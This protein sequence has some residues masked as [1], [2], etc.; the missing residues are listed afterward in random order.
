MPVRCLIRIVTSQRLGGNGFTLWC[1]FL[2]INVLLMLCFTSF[3]TYL[4]PQRCEQLKNNYNRSWGK[5]SEGTE[6]S[7]A[8]L[9]K[10]AG[11]TLLFRTVTLFLFPSVS[12][13]A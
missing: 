2:L 13:V 8:L 11:P 7:F 12:R 4:L 10:T 3:Q 6:F 1:K 9:L 5:D